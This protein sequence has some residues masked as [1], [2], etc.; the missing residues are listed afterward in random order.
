M[1]K[2]IVAGAGIAVAAFISA[3]SVFAGYGDKTNG[4]PNWQERAVIVLNN[5]CRMAPQQYRDKYVGNYTILLPAN[6]QAVK[7]LYWNLQ[8]N[9]SARYHAVD[10]GTNCDSLT[11]FSCNGDSFSTRLHGFYTKSTSI[12]ENIAWGSSTPQAVLA[13]WI[14]ETSGSSPVPDGPGAGH[15]INLMNSRYREFGVGY[16]Y[17]T[18]TKHYWWVQDFGGGKPDFNNPI[19]SGAHLFIETG[20]TAFYANYFDSLGKPQEASVV[21]DG[22]RYPLVLDVGTDSAGTYVYSTAKASSCRTY[23]FSFT[24]AKSKQWAYPE[25]GHLST[26][27]EGTC[28]RDFVPAESLSVYNDAKRTISTRGRFF[29][30]VSGQDLVLE[31]AD[32]K[33]IPAA[34]SVFDVLGKAVF[35][36]RLAP[37]NA[38]VPGKIMLPLGKNVLPGAYAVIV[39]CRSGERIMR[40]ICRPS[41]R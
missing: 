12:A 17:G 26:Q 19:V 16:E 4:Y 7:P 23:Y 32:A 15:R 37:D 11:H 5:A 14:K 8:L 27:G 13:M 20:K 31:S 36:R 28:T 6:Y 38:G 24:D 22:T 39:E 41:G 34:V 21:I 30:S 3:G 40:K 25:T 33:A 29:I 2:C 10:M 35:K 1:D 18:K 9:T